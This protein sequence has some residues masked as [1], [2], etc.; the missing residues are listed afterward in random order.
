MAAFS[1]PQAEASGSD[2]FGRTASAEEKKRGPKETRKVKDPEGQRDPEDFDEVL[3]EFAALSEP[4]DAR[5][6]GSVTE[7]KNVSPENSAVASK[8]VRPEEEATAD[9]QDMSPNDRLRGNV[10]DESAT[11]EQRD[12]LRLIGAL[13]IA[14]ERM[15]RIVSQAETQIEHYRALDR[16]ASAESPRHG[17]V[18]TPP[19]HTCCR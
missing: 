3:K 18:R 12:V 13:D 6:H 15:R 4:V 7:S 9:R 17:K 5:P 16:A 1:N 11:Q 14:E 19:P 8:G 10:L 2:G